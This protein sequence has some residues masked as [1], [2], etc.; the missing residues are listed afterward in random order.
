MGF[1]N[2]MIFTTIKSYKRFTGRRE[3]PSMLPHW[4]GKGIP[5]HLKKWKT[6]FLSSRTQSVEATEFSKILAKSAQG[7]VLGPIN[8]LSLHRLH[9]NLESL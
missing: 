3:N 1:A 5:D 7:T 9:W 2:N 4:G 8:V 6:S